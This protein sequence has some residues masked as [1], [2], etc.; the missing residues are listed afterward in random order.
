[1]AICLFFVSIKFFS[2]K[3]IAFIDIL[4]SFPTF[5]TA[6]KSVKSVLSSKSQSLYN[7][8]VSSEHLFLHKEFLVAQV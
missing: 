8:P 7:I 1:M 5:I 3:L 2:F 6:D 4:L